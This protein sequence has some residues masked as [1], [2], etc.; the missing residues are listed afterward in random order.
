MESVKIANEITS[1]AIDY[2]ISIAQ[3]GLKKNLREHDR[4]KYDMFL[5][6][7]GAELLKTGDPKVILNN[8]GEKLNLLHFCILKQENLSISYHGNNKNLESVIAKLS[9][10]VNS[11]KNENSSIYVII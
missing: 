9:L 7:Y 10:L 1:S 3:S 6:N 2:A 11:I 4:F 8:I 5:C